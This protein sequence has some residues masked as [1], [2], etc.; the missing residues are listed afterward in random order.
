MSKSE[1][2]VM[3][4]T[5]VYGLILTDLFA[6][7]H[8]LLRARK[9]I[10]WHWLPILSVW[11]LF[12]M[13]VK[14]WW[15]LGVPQGSELQMDY[16][17]FIIYSHFLILYYLLVSASLP[18]EIPHKG[19]DLKDYYFQNRKYFWGLMVSV[20]L[21]SMIIYLT[22]SLMYNSHISMFRISGNIFFTSF[23]I[24]LLITNK[25]CIY[26]TILILFFI[27]QLLEMAGI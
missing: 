20:T 2:I 27:V 18:D 23:S 12:L 22:N 1:I 5:I 13:I 15:S 17:I 11:Y 9:I 3:L 4:F 26:S 24:L 16:S 6:S 8:K 14:N 10:K 19:V 21:L 7:I 25:Y